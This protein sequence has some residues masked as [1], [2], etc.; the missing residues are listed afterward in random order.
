[1]EVGEAVEF[2]GSL[3]RVAAVAVDPR[4]WTE[5]TLLPAFPT[6]EDEISKVILMRRAGDERKPIAVVSSTGHVKGD[7]DGR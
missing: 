4:G 5:T 1:M 6:P 3:Y 7:A 2:D